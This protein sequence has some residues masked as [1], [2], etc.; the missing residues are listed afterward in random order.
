MNQASAAS[1]NKKV[2]DKFKA[3]VKLVEATK[4]D[5][6]AYKQNPNEQRKFAQTKADESEENYSE[7]DEFENDDGDDDEAERKLMNIRKA[8]TR[9]NEKASKVVVTSKE[10]TAKKLKIGPATGQPIKLEDLKKQFALHDK[11]HELKLPAQQPLQQYQ[12]K[13]A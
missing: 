1:L 7:E 11:T 13:Q 12:V 8:L 6:Q 10:D 2:E 9:E 5:L 3:P 4:K